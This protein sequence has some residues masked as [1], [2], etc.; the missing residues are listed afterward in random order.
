VPYLVAAVVCVG[1][2]CVV[3]L[4]LTMAVIRRLREHSVR[5]AELGDPPAGA[6][7]PSVDRM[8]AFTATAVDGQFVTGPDPDRTVVA[9]FAT[10]CPACTVELPRLLRYVADE[11]HD[12][13]RVLAV[14]AGLDTAKSERM[15]E[16]L[17]GVAAV[18]REPLDGTVCTAFATTRFPTFYLFDDGGGVRAAA[19]LIAAL[20]HRV[21]T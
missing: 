13:D 17:R 4:L 15:V 21:P 7:E 11:G 5:L 18:V 6:V 16:Q 12:R 1:A 14:V 3:N 10:D 19:A 9:F 8:P 20:P 2:L